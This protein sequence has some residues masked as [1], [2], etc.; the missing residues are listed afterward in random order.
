MPSETNA[1]PSRLNRVPVSR[2]IDI[3]DECYAWDIDVPTDV[4]GWSETQIRAFFLSGGEQRPHMAMRDALHRAARQ[5][6]ARN[7]TADAVIALD[8]I[9]RATPT[10]HRTILG[11]SPG[12]DV[13]TSASVT[14]AFRQQSL[15]VH[16]DKNQDG[17]AA[18]AFL[19]LQAA[20]DALRS[21]G[22]VAASPNCASAVWAQPSATTRTYYDDPPPRRTRHDATTEAPLPRTGDFD[23]DCGLCDGDMWDYYYWRDPT[24]GR[25]RNNL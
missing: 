16:P 5:P 25:L 17:R 18:E 9:L 2:V 10:D 24:T 20:H 19:R 12:G 15:L 8:R 22:Y 6:P 14:S 11:L 4:A 23:A 1:P 3:R 21:Q 7:A 13:I